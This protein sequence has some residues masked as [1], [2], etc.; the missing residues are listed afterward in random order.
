MHLIDIY[1]QKVGLAELFP[2]RHIM[3]LE[4]ATHTKPHPELFDRAFLSLGLGEVDRPY[5]LAFEDDPRGIMSAKA[6]GLYVC[7]ITTRYSA[8]ELQSL[9]VAPDLIAGT[10][11]E[12]ARQLYGG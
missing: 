12:F 1:L 9:E 8:D 2:G 4:S 7:A 10:Y 6:A 3:S 5:V 11:D